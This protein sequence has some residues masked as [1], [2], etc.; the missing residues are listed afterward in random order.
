MPP[1][2]L[3]ESASS[4]KPTIEACWSQGFTEVEFFGSQTAASY[5][6]NPLFGGEYQ[7]TS[8][9]CAK[10]KSAASGVRTSRLGHGVEIVKFTVIR[11]S[12][13]TACP[14]SR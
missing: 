3:F 1:R 13:G 7:V 2:R 12:V 14:A 6:R 4:G 10:G 11:V 9:R 8:T 5:Q